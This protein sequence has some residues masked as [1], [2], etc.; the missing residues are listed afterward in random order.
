MINKNNEKNI[1][2]DLSS[3]KYCDS[4]GLSSLL[5]GY[6]LCNEAE[7]SYVLCGIQPAVKKLFIISQLDTILTVTP[8]IDEA[9]AILNS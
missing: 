2:I 6:R 5:I 9:L 1:I 4:S 7:G 8:T 3:V